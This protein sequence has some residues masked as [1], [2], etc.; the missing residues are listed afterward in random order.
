M[1]GKSY[2]SLLWLGV[3]YSLLLSI[4]IT[5]S[6]EPLPKFN[7][8]TE[9][10]K[11][12]QFKENGQL[13]GIAVD[14]LVLMLE[15][16]GSDQQRDDIQLYPWA[17]G[18]NLLKNQK[19]TILFSTT[20]LKKR[21][22]LFKW[23]GPIFQNTTYLIG[24]KSRKYKIKSVKDLHNYRIGTIINDASEEYM[25]NIG[26][27]LKKLQR[28]T[29]AVYNIKKLEIDRIDFVVCGWLAFVHDAREAGVNPDLYAPVYTVDVADV[30]YAFNIKTPDWIIRKFQAAL[31]TIKSEGKLDELFQRYSHLLQ[32]DD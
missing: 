30:S 14:L 25:K 21:E 18:Y 27:P 9:D 32:V 26:I 28:N 11:P 6:A 19:N 20:R 12:Y 29:K 5:V 10:W 31:D 13:K 1:T 17:R 15:K 24:K 2:F 7:I 4:P 16:I 22:K 23:V 8:I 3:V